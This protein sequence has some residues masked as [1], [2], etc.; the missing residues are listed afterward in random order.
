MSKSTDPIYILNYY[1]KQVKTSWTYSFQQAL[2][3]SIS[4]YIY[5]PAE[6]AEDEKDN[7][8]VYLKP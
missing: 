5:L 1:V 7:W 6:Y 2:R 8:Q 3:T 4:K